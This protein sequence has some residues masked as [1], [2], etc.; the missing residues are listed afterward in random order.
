MT[1]PY[2]KLPDTA[3]WRSA[4][5]ERSPLDPGPLYTAK[6]PVRKKSAIV[7][8]GSCFAQHIGRHLTPDR[9]HI[10]AIK[11]EDDRAIRVAD[12]ALDALERDV[13]V[14]GLA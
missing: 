12:L 14:G 6:F 4:V 7:T 11:R 3:Y 2:D 8:A 1:S 9:R 13:R 5:G 10:N